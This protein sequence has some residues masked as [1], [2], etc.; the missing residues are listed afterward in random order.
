MIYTY[1]F[2][3]K[4]TKIKIAGLISLIQHPMN[5]AKTERPLW[6]RKTKPRPWTRKFSI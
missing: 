5:D 6:I 4:T 2:D 3:I 1:I